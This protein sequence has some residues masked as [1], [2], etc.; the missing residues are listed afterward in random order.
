MAGDRCLLRGGSKLVWEL[1]GDEGQ[2][3]TEEHQKERREDRGARKSDE[4]EH[5]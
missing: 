2:M 3:G 1:C 4:C 5:G